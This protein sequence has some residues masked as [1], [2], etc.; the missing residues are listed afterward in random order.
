M[1]VRR[2]LEKLEAE[3]PTNAAQDETP[4]ALEVYFKTIENERRRQ[5][6]EPL[7]PLTPEEER[8]RRETDNDPEF[9]T[10]MEQIN[11]QRKERLWREETSRT[12]R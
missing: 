11:Q 3:I 12:R 5:A 6:R 9:R 4:L 1:N 2:R 7:I 10:Y 8:W